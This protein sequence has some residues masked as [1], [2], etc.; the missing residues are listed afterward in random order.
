M[1][2][3]D[4]FYILNI[5]LNTGGCDLPT[6]RPEFNNSRSGFDNGNW[7]RN[8]RWGIVMYVLLFY[9]TRTYIC[10]CAH[11]LYTVRTMIGYT[12]SQRASL[13]RGLWGC[14]A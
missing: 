9:L 10:M 8:F 1:Q 12:Y 13:I 3:S 11:V 5:G 7:R 6:G 2:T 4:L 14:D